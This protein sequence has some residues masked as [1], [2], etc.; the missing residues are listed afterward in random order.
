MDTGISG[1]RTDTAFF[2]QAP[3]DKSRRVYDFFIG[4]CMPYML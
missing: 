2:T 4:W 3:A 1:G